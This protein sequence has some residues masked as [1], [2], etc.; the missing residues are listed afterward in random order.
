MSNPVTQEH[1]YGCAV[2]CVAYILCISYNDALKLF[3]KP[4]QAWREGFYCV[5]IINALAKGAKIYE[6]CRTD[7]QKNPY[8]PVNCIVYVESSEKYPVGHYLT[9]TINNQ[10]MNSWI[11]CPVICPTLSGFEEQL[12]GIVSYVIYPSIL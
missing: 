3:D 1:G 10:W 12:P 11:N 4:Q 5:D 7:D 2:A 9:K 6:F 8:F